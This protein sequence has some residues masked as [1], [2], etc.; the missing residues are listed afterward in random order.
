MSNILHSQA[1]E[2]P[3]SD[4]LAHVAGNLKRLRAAAGISQQALADRSGI[5]RRMIAAVE[6]GDANISLSSLDRLAAALDVGFVDLVRDPA[7][8]SLADIGALTWRGQDPASLA[9]LLGSAPAA[10]EAQMWLWTL[11][12]GETYRAE[13]DPD[14]WHEMI[15]VMAGVLRLT[16][17]DRAEDY[18]TGSHVIFPSSQSYA[19]ANPG[20]EPLRFLRNVIS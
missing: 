17:G 5:S 13:P 6:T 19:Y 9:L 12:P 2:T 20:E 4:V 15:Y 14:G 8:Q 7:R 3:R 18:S 1:E 11:A 10:R 16:Q